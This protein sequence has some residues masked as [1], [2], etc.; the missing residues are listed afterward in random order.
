MGKMRRKKGKW[1]AY[2]EKYRARA[3]LR[4]LRGLLGE[5]WDCLKSGGCKNDKTHKI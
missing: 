1:P 2:D 4:S 3:F 5:Q